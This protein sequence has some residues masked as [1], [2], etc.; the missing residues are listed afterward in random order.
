MR[1]PVPRQDP[2]HQQLRNGKR[3]R[4]PQHLRLRCALQLGLFGG[5]RAFH[6][7]GFVPHQRP[8]QAI[9]DRAQADGR[10]R[11]RHQQGHPLGAK[12]FCHVGTRLGECQWAAALGFSSRSARVGMSRGKQQRKEMTTGPL[13]RARIAA[14]V[15]LAADGS[16][17]QHQH[18]LIDARERIRQPRSLE[19]DQPRQPSRRSK[20]VKGDRIGRRDSVHD[21]GGMMNQALAAG[22]M[23][24]GPGRGRGQG[25]RLL[26]RGIHGAK[27]QVLH[28]MSQA[29]G[30]LRI[31]RGA[32]ADHAHHTGGLRMGILFK[33]DQEPTWQ[34]G[35]DNGRIGGSVFSQ[36]RSRRSRRHVGRQE[37]SSEKRR[38]KRQG[39]GDATGKRTV[40]FAAPAVRSLDQERRPHATS[41]ASPQRRA[42]TSH[43]MRQRRVAPLVVSRCPISPPQSCRCRC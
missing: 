41:P 7:M 37:T 19:I 4:K 28:Q 1:P 32:P 13:A 27:S 25:E 14:Q 30:T 17:F 35:E 24:D 39:T 43:I 10:R 40:C 20:F 6:R 5:C 22:C 2:S 8:G 3:R 36:D 15:L 9:N 38:G 29:I 31:G 42:K 11:R 34:R 12:V 23:K 18:G 26:R 16:A 21:R 33:N